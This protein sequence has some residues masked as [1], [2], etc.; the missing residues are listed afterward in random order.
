MDTNIKNFDFEK[1]LASVDEE[2]KE[3]LKGT[4]IALLSCYL[5]EDISGV[6]LVGSADSDT[7]G[8]ITINANPMTAA[9]MLDLGLKAVQELNTADA[10]P[11]EMFN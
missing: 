9:S 5:T 7:L 8:F 6:L 4:L 2:A 3:H 1:A 10:P 11:K